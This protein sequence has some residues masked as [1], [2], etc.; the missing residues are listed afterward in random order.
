[1]RDCVFVGSMLSRPYI[2]MLLKEKKC[3]IVI[4]TFICPLGP[5]VGVSY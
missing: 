5:M 1:M 2:D 3:L 4:I